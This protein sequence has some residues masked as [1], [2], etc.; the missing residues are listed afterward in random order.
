MN[1]L[2]IG[3]VGLGLMGKPMAKRL[4][5][6]GYQL[7]IYN[8]DHSKCT[9]LIA[10]GARECSCPREVA[11]KSDI[12]FTMLTNTEALISISE[13]QNGILEGLREGCTHIDCSTIMDSAST[14]LYDIYKSQNKNFIHAPVLGSVPQATD[15]TLLMFPGGD[16]EIIEK[17]TPILSVL[18]KSI[19]KTD[20]PSKSSNLKIALNSI[21]AGTISMLSQ[22]MVFLEKAGVDNSVFLEILSNSTLNSLTMQFK[23]NNILDRNFTP[24]FTVQNMLKDTNYMSNSCKK[25]SCRSDITDAI[26]K[27][28]ADAIALGKGNEDY[29]AIIK[30]FEASAEVKVKRK[31]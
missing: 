8:R 29:S 1:T 5:E 2:N 9:E 31:D 30:A 4:I 15:G 10:L 18:S 24:R 20:H 27:L 25:L 17:F 3:F 19:W 23:G 21:I 6:S 28:L 22:S 14:L 26:A 7:N 12:V 16:A 13:D 11:E